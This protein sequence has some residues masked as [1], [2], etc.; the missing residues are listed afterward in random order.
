[1]LD[2]A[3]IGGLPRSVRIPLGRGAIVAIR[4]EVGL[5]HVDDRRLWIADSRWA[6]GGW[7][8]QV[9][10]LPVR[11]PRGTFPVH[12]YR[13]SDEQD[14]IHACAVIAFRRASA[15]FSR[16]LAIRNVMRPDLTEGIIVDSAEIALHSS[17]TL[18]MASGFGDG[19]YPVV[20]NQTWGL[21][22]QSIVVDFEVWENGSADQGAEELD[23]AE[24]QERYR[25]ERMRRVAEEI[26]KGT[27]F[28]EGPPCPSCGEPLRT[29]KAKQCFLC[30][31]KSDGPIA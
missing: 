8:D 14:E 12:A 1:M 6:D 29:A 5:L 25:R 2:H 13:F 4:V 18:A 27:R 9:P 30:G 7:S 11:V 19:Y 20:A 22:L 17:N 15:V 31:H 23:A 28:R 3:S 26:A 24:V 21:R 10:P 16:R